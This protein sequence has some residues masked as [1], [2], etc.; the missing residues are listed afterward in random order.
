MRRRKGI[1]ENPRRERLRN[2]G[3]GL[4]FALLAGQLGYMMLSTWNILV[5]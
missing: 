1:E 3:A 2:L 4:L 5:K